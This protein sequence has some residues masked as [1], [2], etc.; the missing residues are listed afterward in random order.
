MRV[1]PWV[2]VLFGAVVLGALALDLV[3][4][5]GVAATCTLAASYGVR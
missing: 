3:L 1:A 4:G 2:W 5:A